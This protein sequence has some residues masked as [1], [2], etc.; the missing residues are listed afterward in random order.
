M[1]ACIF[2]E[3]KQIHFFD[4]SSQTIKKKEY[5]LG[6]NAYSRGLRYMKGLL[7]WVKEEG[8][9]R[10]VIVNMS[11]WTLIDHGKEFPQQQNNFDCGTFAIVC[12][13]Y[14]V[15]NLPLNFSQEDME[16]WRHKIAIDI[17][18]GKLRY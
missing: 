9:Q 10:G 11:E 12:A 6:S 13:D 15:D 3:K 1:L 16:F 2:V 7:Q 18:R 17:L 5:D 14:L 4:S 8:K